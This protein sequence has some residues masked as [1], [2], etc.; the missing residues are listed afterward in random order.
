MANA[1]TAFVDIK[2]RP[3]AVAEMAVDA[4]KDLRELAD[5]LDKYAASKTAEKEQ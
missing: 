4:A 3:G 1:G 5:V 2:I